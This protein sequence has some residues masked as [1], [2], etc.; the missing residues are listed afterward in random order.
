MELFS[1]KIDKDLTNKIYQLIEVSKN[2]GKIKKGL[3]LKK[4][5]L[6]L[7]KLWSLRLLEKYPKAK[8]ANGYTINTYDIRIL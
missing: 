1:F 5:P 3:F 6:P 8:N 2:T 4:I 7:L